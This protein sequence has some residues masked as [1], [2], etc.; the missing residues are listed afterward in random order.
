MPVETA[1]VADGDSR[2]W[3]HCF[4]NELRLMANGTAEVVFGPLNVAGFFGFVRHATPIM[5]IGDSAANVTADCRGDYIRRR[6][7]FRLESRSDRR[8]RLGS[9]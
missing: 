7:R 8:M 6:S 4:F 3:P 1:S 2:R 9:M 5:G